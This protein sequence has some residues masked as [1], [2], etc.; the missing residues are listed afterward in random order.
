MRANRALHDA[1]TLSYE[2]NTTSK[3]NLDRKRT[4]RVSEGLEVKTLRAEVPQHIFS[5]RS[6]ACWFEEISQDNKV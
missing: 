1:K 5:S 3:S 2:R 4:E 6:H